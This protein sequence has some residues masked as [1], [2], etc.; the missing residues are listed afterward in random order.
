LNFSA[1]HDVILLRSGPGLW[2]RKPKVTPASRICRRLIVA[3]TSA[4]IRQK[5]VFQLV[6]SY[7]MAFEGCAARTGVYLQV[8]H[9]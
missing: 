8:R 3:K 7:V 4:H 1:S 2:G 6:P 5:S 9:R